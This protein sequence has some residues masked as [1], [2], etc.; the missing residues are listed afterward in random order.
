MPRRTGCSASG[1]RA[2]NGLPALGSADEGAHG[3]ITWLRAYLRI[4]RSGQRLPGGAIILGRGA[5][6]CS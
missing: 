1:I 4:Q 3:V 6:G 5:V 2:A